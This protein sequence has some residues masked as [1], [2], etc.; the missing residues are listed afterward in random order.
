MCTDILIKLLLYI[1]ILTYFLLFALKLVLARA[2]IYY[3]ILIQSTVDVL[4][5]I[6]VL[7]YMNDESGMKY[8]ITV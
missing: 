5:Y 2:Y 6:T 1:T 3:F 7:H 4:Q 8:V